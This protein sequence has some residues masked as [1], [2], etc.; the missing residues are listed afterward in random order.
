MKATNVSILCVK[1]S[2]HKRMGNPDVFGIFTNV[3]R[4]VLEFNW[5]LENARVILT[6]S[7]FRDFK[8]FRC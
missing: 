5:L 7:V 1:R 6:L 2:W 4:N 3:F 8:L